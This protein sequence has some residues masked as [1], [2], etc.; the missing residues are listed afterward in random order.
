MCVRGAPLQDRHALHV[1]L[2]AI[3]EVV[4]VS[5]PRQTEAPALVLQVPLVDLTVTYLG[6]DC[7]PM[8]LDAVNN[9]LALFCAHCGCGS[10]HHPP[11]RTD[12]EPCV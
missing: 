1:L 8:L 9:H 3:E 7:A 10:H 6:G 11:R 5:F 2:H 12:C 4:H